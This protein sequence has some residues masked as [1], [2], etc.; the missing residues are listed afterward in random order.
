LDFLLSFER[1][2][3]YD[4]TMV[5]VA[6]SDGQQFFF[7]GLRVDHATDR[8]G[9]VMFREAIRPAIGAVMVRMSDVIS[10]DLQKPPPDPLPDRPFGFQPSVK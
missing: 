4:D 10:V 8:P 3:G 9:F 6:L 1:E 7:Q 5:R 2:S